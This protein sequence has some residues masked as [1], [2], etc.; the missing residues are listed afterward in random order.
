MKRNNTSIKMLLTL[1]MLFLLT[2]NTVA[3]TV[4]D[5]YFLLSNE[6]AD[7]FGV[8]ADETATPGFKEGVIKPTTPADWIRWCI[9]PLTKPDVDISF[10]Y[11][12]EGV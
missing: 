1:A 4:T 6:N 7:T 10:G 2:A 3:T 12:P 8:G 11:K 9:K 5:G